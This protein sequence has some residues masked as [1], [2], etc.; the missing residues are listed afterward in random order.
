M[1]DAASLAAIRLPTILRDAGSSRRDAAA[2][3]SE[4]DVRDLQV[5]Q[6]LAWIDPFYR[7][8]PRI[9]R[10]EARGRDYREEDKQVLAEV[11]QPTV[12]ARR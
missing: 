9:R 6:K 1:Q 10:L 7:A 11:S 3:F 5:W 4:G 8:D 12:G 2:R